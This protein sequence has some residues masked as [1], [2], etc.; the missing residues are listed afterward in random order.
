VTLNLA[1][2]LARLIDDARAHG[3]QS[4]DL[5]ALDRLLHRH[6]EALRRDLLRQSDMLVVGLDD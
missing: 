6:S 1:A 2:E 3:C 4:L 5:V